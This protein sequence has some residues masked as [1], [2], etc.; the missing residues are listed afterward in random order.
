MDTIAQMNSKSGMDKRQIVIDYDLAFNPCSTSHNPA[1]H[2]TAH[3]RASDAINK[4]QA[5]LYPCHRLQRQYAE[6]NSYYMEIPLVHIFFFTNNK[7]RMRLIYMDVYHYRNYF[8]GKSNWK[9]QNCVN[10]THLLF[11]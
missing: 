11:I 9:T 1:Q 3:K 5:K 6:I 4:M 10:F 7:I 2:S 8:I